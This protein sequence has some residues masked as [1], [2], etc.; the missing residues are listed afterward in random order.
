MLG[1]LDLIERWRITQQAYLTDTP[2]VTVHQ[3]LDQ[4]RL[5]VQQEMTQLLDAFLNR[6]ITLKE[7][8]AMFQQKT[9][10]AWNVFRMRGTSGGMYLNKLVKYID[11]DTFTS[12]LRAGLRLPEDTR[13]GQQHMQEL[14]Q[15]FELLITQ[16][17]ISR[18]Q[19]QPARI[20]FLLSSWWHL[21]NSQHWPIFFPLVHHMLLNE[22]EQSTPSPSPIDAYFAFRTHFLSLARALGVSLWELEHIVTWKGRQSLGEEAAKKMTRSSSLF[23]AQIIPA[24]LETMDGPRAGGGMEQQNQKNERDMSD[25]TR[26]QWLLAR[27]GHQVGCDVWIA[28]NDQSKSWNGER[29]GDLSLKTLPPLLDSASRRIINL[30]DVLWL[31]GD[32][33]VAAYEIE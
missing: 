24:H 26:I 30:I 11:D 21:Q 22:D 25:H 7:F 18:S 31:R 5:Q 32:D 4:R 33:V 19:L 14:T 15:Y 20:P 29:L 3:A 9:Q 27:I 6:A 23:G 28:A 16:Q 2:R 1:S 10:G 12:H 8:N 17:K 13:E